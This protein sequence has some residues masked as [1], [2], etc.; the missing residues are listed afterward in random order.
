[1]QHA[2]LLRWIK[3]FLQMVSQ[4]NAAA[5][6]PTARILDFM[7]HLIS[8]FLI[9]R[10]CE[11]ACRFS[12]WTRS[13]HCHA[14]CNFQILGQKWCQNRYDMMIWYDFWSTKNSPRS[15]LSGDLLL[16]LAATILQGA[17][18]RTFF[19]ATFQLKFHRFCHALW[20]RLS[21]SAKGRW[22]MLNGEALGGPLGFL[23]IEKTDQKPWGTLRNP[24]IDNKQQATHLILLWT[25]AATSFT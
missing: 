24:I 16:P 22:G 4:Q 15:H 23:L 10:A 11:T 13:N 8:W 19:H 12:D 2:N 17:A 7:D 21:C 20:T 1:M 6:S 9:W 25:N 5:N 18:T 14:T 3:S